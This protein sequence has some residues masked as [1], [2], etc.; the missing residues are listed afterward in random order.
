MKNI[1]PTIK[2]I[3]KFI[4]AGIKHI[5][6]LIYYTGREFGRD[7]I[8]TRAAALT[9]F[10]MLSLVP[11][12]MLTFAA[13]KTFGGESLVENTVKPLIFRLLSTGTGEVISSA[14]DQLIQNSRAGA[15]GAIG[16]VFLIIT[17]FSLMDQAEFTLNFIWAEK[18]RR[19]PVK[20]WMFYWAALSIFPVLVGLSVSMTAYLGSL[21]EVQEI[22]VQVTPRIYAL[23]PFALQ[24]IA[25]F[26]LYRY[27]PRHKVRFI[28]AIAGAVAASIIW[29]F[30]KKGYL[31]YA[32]N[33]INYNV[34]Y[35]SLAT[36][37]LFMIWIFITWIIILLGAELSFAWQ[38]YRV[39]DRSMKNVDVPFQVYEIL[40]LELMIESARRFLKGEKAINLEEYINSK[41]LQPNL[42]E[43]SAEKLIQSDLLKS[44][45][46]ELLLAKNP[47]YITVEDIIQ[48]IKSGGE[49]ELNFRP[50]EEH[51]VI[52]DFLTTLDESSKNIRSDWSLRKIINEFEELKSKSI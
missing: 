13:F 37:P 14:I 46:G 20:R 48:A 6:R 2:T 19:S 32:S 50:G 15:L 45:N 18:T 30:V 11:L 12:L 5:L 49:Y 41:T 1:K 26:L 25:F 47:E 33:A 40:G 38:N 36:I 4:V 17:A 8:L 44:S 35:G 51:Q 39:I 7:Q 42:V 9:F 52:K 16:F 21:K 43:T 3:N 24:G 29:E 28:P 23:F 34:I 10:T 31:L 22:T 27:L